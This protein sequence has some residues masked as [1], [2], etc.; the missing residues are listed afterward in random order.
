MRG[1][2]TV[3]GSAWRVVKRE[4]SNHTWIKQ[5]CFALLVALIS[6]GGAVVTAEFTVWKGLRY[7]LKELK[8][9]TG[10]LKSQLD[11]R[12]RPIINIDRASVYN[13]DGEVVIETLD[14]RKKRL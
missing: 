1:E 6:A 3:A 4:R 9:Q 8:N 11:Q 5:L 2:K 12:V 13:T 14:S 10:L 7:E